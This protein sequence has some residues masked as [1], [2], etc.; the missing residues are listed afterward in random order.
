MIDF[1]ALTLAPCIDI[2]ARPII[3]TPQ[4]SQPARRAEDG[5]IIPAGQPYP[6]RGVWA[7]RPVDVPVEGGGIMSTQVHTLGIAAADFEFPPAP[8]DYIEIP[9]HMSLPRIGLCQV[10]DTDDDGQ[11]GTSLTLKVIGP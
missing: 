2:F 8:D 9:A 11:G 3:V 10:E 4:A 1:A 5:T 6:S 7:S